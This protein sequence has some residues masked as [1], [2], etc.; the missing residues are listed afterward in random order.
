MGKVKA[1]AV[2]VLRFIGVSLAIALGLFA[3]VSVSCL[4][5]TRCTNVAYS[6]RM[7]WVS[8]AAFAVAMPGILSALGTH[9]GYYSDPMTAGMDAKVSRTIA[10][11]GHLSLSKRTNLIVRAFSVGIMGIGISALID[12][13]G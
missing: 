1:V 4:I 12:V 8:M 13:L 6:E 3:V 2:A 9:Q 11:D 5:G 7:F 10:E